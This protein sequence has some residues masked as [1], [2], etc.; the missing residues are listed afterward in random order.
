ML[1]KISRRSFLRGTLAGTLLSGSLFAAESERSRNVW[2]LLSDTHIPGDRTKLGGNPKVNPVDHLATVRADVLSGTVGRPGGVI[3]TGDCAYLQGQSADYDT[4]LDEFTP[5]REAEIDVRFVMGNHDNR[6]NY[7]DA[8]ARKAGQ[9]P[10]KK[11]P[12]RLHSVIET[13]KANLILLDSLDETDKT[14]GRFGEAQIQWLETQLD[15][16]KD[17]PT[18]LFAHHNLDYTGQIA[19]NPHALL[20]TQDFWK[21]VKDRR[22]VKAYI[23]GHTH[24]WQHLK[25]DGVHLVS[26][27]PTAWRFDQTQPCGWVLCELKDDGVKL[28]LRSM[29][30][31]HP[32]HDQVL[33]LTW[34]N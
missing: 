2:A 26:L 33:E 12:E 23:F 30:P 28:T 13:P 1:P 15:A 8:L 16:R 32:K 5:F 19:K 34:R 6:K 18:I 4:L 25:K 17:K 22:Q 3:V 10:L 9:E 21:V 24:V 31:E 29:D 27:P 20:D 11:I 14:P 7:L